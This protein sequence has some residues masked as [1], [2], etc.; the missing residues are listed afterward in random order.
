MGRGRKKIKTFI[1]G[2]TVDGNPV[3]TG[4]FHFVS[5]YGFPL[6]EFLYEAQKENMIVDWVDYY[7]T[8][9]LKDMKSD[10]ILTQ[11]ESAVLEVYGKTYC[12]AVMELFELYISTKN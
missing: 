3:I 11:V 5:T 6:V 7:E 10:R 12:S 2:E 1:N 8:A 9:L 4:V